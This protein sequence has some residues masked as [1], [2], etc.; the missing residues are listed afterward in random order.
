MSLSVKKGRIHTQNTP[1]AQVLLEKH[2]KI[3]EQL[4]LLK[5]SIDLLIKESHF[6]LSEKSFF[7]HE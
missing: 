4:E 5:I 2:A 1:M 7:E 6:A 3:D